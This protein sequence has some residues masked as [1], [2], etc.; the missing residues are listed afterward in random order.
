MSRNAPGS[1]FDFEVPPMSAGSFDKL[2]SRE[3]AR[4]TVE[5]DAGEREKQALGLAEPFSD[6][7]G[8]LSLDWNNLWG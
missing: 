5:D 1:L 4:L 6:N 2:L 3:T 8:L 7:D